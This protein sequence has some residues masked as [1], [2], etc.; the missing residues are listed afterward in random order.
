[1]ECGRGDRSLQPF[2]G[3]RRQ[4]RHQADRANPHLAGKLSSASDA[5]KAALYAENG[6]WYDAL[7]S[8]SD[9]IDK[10]PKD[11]SLRQERADLLKQVG[12]DGTAMDATA[13]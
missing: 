4:R 13:P 9:Q 1:M 2:V 12:M 5:D 11:T 7:Q 10:S 3:H 8:I 6:I